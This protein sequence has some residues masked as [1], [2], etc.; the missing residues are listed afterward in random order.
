MGEREREC[1]RERNLLRTWVKSSYNYKN[2]SFKCVCDK[3]KW[4]QQAW[5]NITLFNSCERLL[6]GL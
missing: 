6:L 4:K 1:A 3:V 5:A 2:I